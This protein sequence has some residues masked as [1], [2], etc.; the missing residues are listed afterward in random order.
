MATEPITDVRTHLQTLFDHGVMGSLT[1]GQLLERFLKAEDVLAE[2]AF[3][4]LVQ[5]HGPMVSRVCR[6]ALGDVHDAEDASQ[7]VFLVL[8]RR[9]GS[10]RRY[11][12]AASWL[13]GVA[14]RIAARARRDA[15]R[16]RKHE[17]R[18]AEMAMQSVEETSSGVT[19][20][21][22]Y[23]EIDKLPEVYRAAVVLCHLEGLSHEQS[24]SRLGCPLRTLQSRLLR[25]R[26]RLRER[27]TR[28][29]V[30]LPAVVPP[31]VKPVSPPNAWIDA[32]SRAARA[33]ATGRACT[34]ASLGASP[35]AV[36][37]AE[38]ALRTA[39]I[40]PMLT[41]AAV[42][43]TACLA[44]LI[45]ASAR[46]R[47]A[48]GS[49]PAPLNSSTPPA[50]AQQEN[51]PENRTLEIRV[52][53]R[54]SRAPIEGVE[55]RVEIDSGAR[56]GL[57]GEPELLTRLVTDKEGGCRVEFPRELPK[58]IYVTARKPGYAIRGYAPLTEAGGRCAAADSYDGA[59]ARDFDRRFREAPRRAADRWGDRHHHGPSRCGRVA[60]LQLC[61]RCNR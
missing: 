45:A 31:L 38:S 20:E 55:V 43:C 47:P 26:A 42:L 19:W 14:R 17:R 37:L 61:A 56:A 9:A 27:L 21:E 24:A 58:E 44:V 23:Q 51:D 50:A 10:V 11:E 6:S 7:A 2:A 29:G 57:G 16:R 12:S 8:A 54:Q 4:A 60:R 15:A 1:D 40:V 34:A 48:A 22:L 35:T 36:A 18:R 32:T 5:R 3:A 13:Y 28:P 46:G 59:G 41:A 30:S 33:F 25:A 53:D 49:P 39:M 52:V